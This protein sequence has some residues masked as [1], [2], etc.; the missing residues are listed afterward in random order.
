MQAR[1]KK[2]D[3]CK[4]SSNIPQYNVWR[5][6]VKQL[7]KISKTQLYSNSVNNAANPKQLWQTLNDIT[8]KSAKTV[9]NFINDKD[10]NPIL[11]P[12]IA[13]NSFNEFFTSIHKTLATDN[14][15]YSTDTTDTNNI[16]EH[17][18]KILQNDSKFCI[19][20]VTESFIQQQFQNLKVTKATG[21]DDISAKYLKM[22]AP[23]ICK[24]L[25]K[26]LNLSIKTNSYPDM[27][28]KAKV[29]PIF[30]KGSRADINNYRTISVLPI[31]NSIFERHIS[32]CM[33]DFL[34]T[35]KLL[36]KN[37]SGFRL[38][39]SCQT[40]L[41]KIIDNWLNALNVSETVGTVFLDLSKAFDLVNHKLLLHK[42]AAY[43]FSHNSLSWFESYLTNRTQEVHVS[44][45]L[46]EPKLIS[47][48]VPQ[49]S[50]LGPLPFLVY[51][52][53]LPLA[54]TCC[55]LDLFADDA[56]LSSSDPSVLHLANRLNADF[57]SGMKEM[58]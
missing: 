45:K 18:N 23:I 13:A 38:S 28:K 21:L 26:I 2:R 5:N 6:K 19:S 9:T 24:P 34:E 27:L 54:I 50:V 43:K 8:G 51:I 56:T 7:I 17:Y 46:S 10:G 36:Y 3:Q 1:K 42:L 37:Q 25:T 22:S 32:Y 49:G 55:A 4:K 57:R 44:G 33:T 16:R 11:D 12:E 48:G 58:T 31:I 29:S 52:N 30:K 40:A 14:T 47:P 15:K 53:D 41:T 35:N 39:H 20:V